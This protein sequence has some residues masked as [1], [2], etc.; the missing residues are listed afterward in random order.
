MFYCLDSENNYLYHMNYCHDHFNF[1][2][3]D[4]AM[5]KAA[6][7][8]FVSNLAGFLTNNV[9]EVTGTVA[10]AIA[11]CVYHRMSVAEL[12]FHNPVHILSMFLFAHQHDIK[13]SDWEQLAIW[14]YNSI[15]IPG[16]VKE[17]NEHQSAGFMRAVLPCGYDPHKLIINNAYSAILET[18]KNMSVSFAREDCYRILDLAWCHLCWDEDGY[19]SATECLRQESLR[20]MSVRKFLDIQTQM[21]GRLYAAPYIFRSQLFQ[22][23]FDAIA[24][25]NIKKTLRKA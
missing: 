21:L 8:D 13:L 24:R 4:N 5:R 12:Y 23:K 16:A 18:S 2:R 1:G 7:L 20:I 11:E 25:H 10:C 9:D 17:R 3:G 6:E 15:Y 14:F 22:Q 19:E